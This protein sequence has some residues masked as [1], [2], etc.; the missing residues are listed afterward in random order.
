MAN[1]SQSS[2]RVRIL[3][4]CSTTTS[5]DWREVALSDCKSFGTAGPVSE[6]LYFGTLSS[7]Q[8]YCTKDGFWFFLDPSRRQGGFLS[9]DQA[10]TVFQN[11]S[12]AIPYELGGSPT[13]TTTPAPA[14]AAVFPSNSIKS[15]VTGESAAPTKSSLIELL[16]EI[17]A[18]FEDRL[19]VMKSG[20]FVSD[21]WAGTSSFS[22]PSELLD[23]FDKACD[24]ETVNP[25]PLIWVHT[26]DSEVPDDVNS[27]WS[28]HLQIFDPVTGKG[29]WYGLV[30]RR[31]D[32]SQAQF[33]DS[34]RAGADQLRR[35]CEDAILKLRAWH[36]KFAKE[37]KPSRISAN[38]MRITDLEEVNDGLYGR[39]Y[40]GIQRPLDRPV[41]VK[42]IKPEWPNAAGA[43]EHARALIRAG[44][45]PAIVTVHSVE[46]VY[47]PQLDMEL[48][49]I[50]MEW[51]EGESFGARLAGPRFSIEEAA[52]IC[53]IVLAGIYHMHAQGVAHGD[54]HLGNVIV[55]P[56]GRPKI[57]DIDANKDFSLGH[58]SKLSREGAINS[59]IDYC[60][61]LIFRTI[62]HS[63]LPPSAI[64]RL[65][66]ALGA[67]TSL[68]D[69]KDVV[70]NR[71]QGSTMVSRNAT[72]S[73]VDPLSMLCNYGLERVDALVLKTVSE[74]ILSGRFL[75]DP[76]MV[77]GVI[78]ALKAEG[79]E[80]GDVL[81]SIEH[82]N[83]KL[84]IK[85]TGG[86]FSRY[87]QL[88]RDG[89][90][91]YLHCFY[92]EYDLHYSDVKS[93]IVKGG[94]TTDSEVSEHLGLPRPLVSHFFD[95]LELRGLCEMS[96][97]NMGAKVIHISVELRREVAGR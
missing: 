5:L 35:I 13:T 95:I 48:P 43:L 38:V 96:H 90:D 55:L 73:S 14:S 16:A 58:L 36:R 92:N 72:S 81:D 47:I 17:I 97:T 25:H 41:A 52:L 59:D 11:A 9:L 15:V 77:P 56:D 7:V 83:N 63:V 37:A 74:K 26:Q 64:A 18:Q 86:R 71:F 33:V 79:I 10:S 21:G 60:R 67:A 54:L 68:Q 42:I 28:E 40:R 8:M 2:D 30:L 50:I 4:H 70:A 39:I 61:G 27:Y 1:E 89:F 87:F 19:E 49:A 91:A 65:D 80:D 45:H 46:D 51:I 82:L 93:A 31:R 62:S 76:I 24:T 85:A 53:E 6:P 32:N 66:A 69:L 20:K 34:H 94:L 75:H 88:L 3:T 44:N 84:F 23:P 78:S 12:R 57:I 29:A 22:L